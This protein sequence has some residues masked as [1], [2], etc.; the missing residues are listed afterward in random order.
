MGRNAYEAGYACDMQVGYV[1]YSWAK[2]LVISTRLKLLA[3][4]KLQ[5]INKD[6]DA[7]FP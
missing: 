6:P 2:I 4:D 3:S 7:V 1:P 5:V